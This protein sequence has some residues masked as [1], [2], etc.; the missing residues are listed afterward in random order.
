M[1][2]SKIKSDLCFHLLICILLEQPKHLDIIFPIV[3]K[4]IF[5]VFSA[6]ST[7]MRCGI[8]ITRLQISMMSGIAFKDYKVQ[9]VIF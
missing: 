6:K 4:N 7:L 9:R 3:I 8:S 1:Y 2:I 5:P